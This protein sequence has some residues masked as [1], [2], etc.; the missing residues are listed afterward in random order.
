MATSDVGLA[1][2]APLP[3]DTEGRNPISARDKH[4]APSG[5]IERQVDSDKEIREDPPAQELGEPREEDMADET[6]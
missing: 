4:V 6:S 1:P 2:Q 3:V 5:G